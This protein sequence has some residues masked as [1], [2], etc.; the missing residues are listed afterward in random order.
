MMT[1]K[2]TKLVREGR[3]AVEVDVE[4]IDDETGWAPYLSIED[5]KRL[6]SVRADLKAGRIDLASLYGRAFEL[7]PVSKDVNPF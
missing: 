1:R 3:Y 5:A 7:L 2:K 6:D 4:L